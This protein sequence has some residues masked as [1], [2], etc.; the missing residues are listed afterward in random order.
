VL[1]TGLAGPF[2]AFGAGAAAASASA[3][4]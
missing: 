4:A 1:I 2:L 3:Y